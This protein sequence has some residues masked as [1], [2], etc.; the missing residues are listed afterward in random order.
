MIAIPRAAIRRGI[1]GFSG[2]GRSGGLPTVPHTPDNTVS[3][4]KL[5]GTI[6]TSFAMAFVSFSG[7]FL[8]LAGAQLVSI[9]YTL[10]SRT[11]L[12]PIRKVPGPRLAALT[13]WYECYYDLFKPGQYVFK[14]KQLHEQYGMG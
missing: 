8:A 9:L 10:F 12:S 11:W 2:L 14:I 5:N 7:L 1:D 4:R 13:S 6:P 3:L